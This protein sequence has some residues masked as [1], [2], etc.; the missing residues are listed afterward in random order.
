MKELRKAKYLANKCSRVAHKMIMTQKK[1]EL[2][3]YEEKKAIFARI[4]GI[5]RA[6]KRAGRPGTGTWLQRVWKAELE[7]EKKRVL[8]LQEM[9]VAKDSEMNKLAHIGLY[10]KAFADRR[11]RKLCV[12]G[13]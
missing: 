4:D 9:V 8:M 11:A 5:E 6:W 7:I 10:W 13:R 12:R 1:N 3:F 2:K